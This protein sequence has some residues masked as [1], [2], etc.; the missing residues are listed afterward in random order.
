MT[1][2]SVCGGC[3]H[4]EARGHA[5]LL[6]CA[7]LTVGEV[8]CGA[9][10]LTGLPDFSH[11]AP[12]GEARGGEATVHVSEEEAKAPCQNTAKNNPASRMLKE[13][14]TAEYMRFLGSDEKARS[15]EQVIL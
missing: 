10:H 2:A 9:D 5:A 7:P 6:S 8:V 4:E 12:L 3:A 1:M 13:D 14:R 15:K 11:G